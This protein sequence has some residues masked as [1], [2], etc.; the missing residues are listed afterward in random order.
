MVSPPSIVV[1]TLLQLCGISIFISQPPQQEQCSTQIPSV[2]NWLF[3]LALLLLLWNCELPLPLLLPKRCLQIF[4]RLHACAELLG[5][6]LVSE[7]AMLFGWCRY[8]R[9]VH[10]QSHRL[11]A[12]WS[13]CGNL[14]LCLLTLLPS[15]LLLVA[16]A[17]TQWREFLVQLLW[18]LPRPEADEC[19]LECVRELS[20]YAKGFVC[21]FQLRREDRL[22]AIRLF[23][24]QAER[25]TRQPVN[26]EQ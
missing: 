25:R 18:K 20:N 10:Y 13:W 12:H 3:G 17:P 22:R 15:A 1:A 5:T 26:V 6:I 14:T 7:L 4:P 16:L 19:L 9:L 24:L 8:K 2:A 11:C 23:Q 21:F